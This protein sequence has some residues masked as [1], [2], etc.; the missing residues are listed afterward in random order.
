L[1]SCP[2]LRL[3]RIIFLSN[4][5]I[6]LASGFVFLQGI[7]LVTGNIP[8]SGM[9]S[10]LFLMIIFIFFLGSNLKDI[11]DYSG[12]KKGKILTLP[13]LLGEKKSKLIISVMLSFA[14]FLSVIILNLINLIPIAIICSIAVFYFINKKRYRE[15]PVFVVYFIFFIILSLDLLLKLLNIK[16]I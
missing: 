11:K 15:T 13:T 9:Q 6:G 10:Q 4:L 5:C 16:V 2:P 7:F 3:K 14:F 8:L 1:Y 12:D